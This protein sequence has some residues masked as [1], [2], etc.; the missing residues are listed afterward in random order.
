ME[1]A[2]RTP[3]YFLPSLSLSLC[4]FVSPSLSLSPSLSCAFFFLGHCG[5][6][7][8]LLLA[9]HGH[10]LP[11]G[12]REGARG[13]EREKESCKSFSFQRYGTVLSLPSPALHCPSSRALLP[14]LSPSSRAPLPTL[15]LR[16][17]PLILISLSHPP[18][19]PLSAIPD[20]HAGDWLGVLHLC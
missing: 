4:L 20:D 9:P 11:A 5:C 7:S 16:V 8:L 12:R 17:W 6:W 19:L 1:T 18:P 10:P 15:S 13:R 14:T 3:T 2:F